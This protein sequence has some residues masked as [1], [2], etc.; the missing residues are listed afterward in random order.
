MPLSTGKTNFFS[1]GVILSRRGQRN[2]EYSGGRSNAAG[3]T[4]K[5]IEKS[6]SVSYN[7]K[8]RN[9]RFRG[10]SAP[11]RAAKPQRGQTFQ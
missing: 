6:G 4:R 3:P 10:F 5:K 8:W 7:Y 11:K 9:M 2:E 1:N